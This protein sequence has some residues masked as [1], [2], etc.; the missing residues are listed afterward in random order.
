MNT[1]I[2]YFDKI[3]TPTTLHKQQNKI[4]TRVCEMGF[5]GINGRGR[6][7]CSWQTIPQLR[8]H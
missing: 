7:N 3:I 6:S 5:I 4:K 2:E 8:A 1:N